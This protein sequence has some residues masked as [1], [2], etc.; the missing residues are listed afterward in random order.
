MGH[1]VHLGREG[2]REGGRSRG[3]EVW[4]KEV[5]AVLTPLPGRWVE[6]EPRVLFPFWG[7]VGQ[8]VLGLAQ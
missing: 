5:W 6:V 8:H 3:V 2:A 4:E 7:A 1:E